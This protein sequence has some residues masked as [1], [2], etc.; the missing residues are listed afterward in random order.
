MLALRFQAVAGT[1]DDLA[2][3]RE[4][5]S[6]S[7]WKDAHDSLSRAEQAAPL[8]P[9][10]L[11]LLG[12][13]AYMLGREDEWL[14]HLELACR[15]HSDAGTDLR[16]ARCAFWIGTQLAIRGDMGPATGWLGR[17]QR[18]VERDGT[19]CVEQAYM[20]LPVAIQHEAAGD[21]AGAAATAAAAVE[22]AERFGDRDLF[23]LAAHVQGTVLVTAGHVREG[24]GL[25][26]EA[27][28]AV[29]AG[30]VSPIVSGIVYCGV[31]LACEQIFEV[32]RAQ[33]WTAALTRWC[34]QQPDLLA[35]TGRCLVHRA[36]LMQLHGDWLDALEEAARAGRRFEEAMN[37]AAAAKACYLRGEVH[38]LR[39][40]FG[41]GE[42]AYREASE[43]GL[44]PQPGWALLRLAQGK[45]D[46]AA[47][48]IRR[49]MGETSEPLKRAG[50]LP[51]YIEIMLVAGDIDE[52][53]GA[54]R[55]LGEIAEQYESALLQTMVAQARGAVELATGDAAAALVN[56]RRGCEAWQELE[57]PYETARTRVLIG[58]ACQ[59][60]G[61][62]DAFAL[63]LDAA[64]R[65]F[66]ELGAAPD[67][68]VVDSLAGRAEAE[69]H[70]LSPRELEV[71]RQ[72]ATGK[73][74]REI[75]AALVISEH[76]VAR[77]VQNIFT[78]L[79]VPSRTA[80][81]AFAFEH[82]LV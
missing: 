28:V 8:A 55:E 18:L 63:E 32:R 51:S 74:N 75:A 62:E 25:L 42:G 52:A 47:A 1:G 54:C 39:G 31:I 10:D 61:D 41:P 53:R 77:H 66:E 58:R 15:R 33:E 67:V 49:V 27:M 68:A 44:E 5:Y 64:R 2:R 30:E 76:T 73:S 50:L 6:S 24:L 17:A 36:Q 34:E 78:K 13:S 4:A 35:F 60:L 70:G 20:L 79:G 48:A 23:A 82:D 80:A 45:A 9:E 72:V 71:L 19:E 12:T 65:V 46:A 81:G 56:L 11:E 7:A 69:P 21:L 16:A 14:Q 40:Q 59:A 29:T 37:R 57:A 26:D 43:L 22:A 3:G 38:R